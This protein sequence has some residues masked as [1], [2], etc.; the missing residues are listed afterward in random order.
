MTYDGE[1]CG[2]AI[3]FDIKYSESFI[4][5]YLSSSPFKNYENFYHGIFYLK[6]PV[7]VEKG[8]V[9]QGNIA[10]KVDL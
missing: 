6:Q 2:V 7:N 9:I 1:V 4:P 3:W 5:L 8:D 10:S